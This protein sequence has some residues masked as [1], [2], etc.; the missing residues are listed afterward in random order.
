MCPARQ[1][2]AQP[3]AIGSG[4]CLSRRQSEPQPVRVTESNDSPPKVVY[5]MCGTGRQRRHSAA[6]VD[7]DGRPLSQVDLDPGPVRVNSRCRSRSR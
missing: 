3:G 2:E 1:G 6:D 4:R 7:R 5:V